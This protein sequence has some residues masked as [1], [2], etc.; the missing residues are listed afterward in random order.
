MNYNKDIIEE[1]QALG[2]DIGIVHEEMDYYRLEY[3]RI[4]KLSPI[5]A[6]N[7]S[8]KFA[9]EK[10]VEKMLNNYLMKPEVRK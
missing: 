5:N 3:N 1:A 2:Y 7:E 6:N 8:L 10:Q 4:N 9:Y